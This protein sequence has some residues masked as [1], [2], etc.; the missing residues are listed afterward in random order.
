MCS[1]SCAVAAP[2]AAGVGGIAAEG[3]QAEGRYHLGE[4]GQEG[5]E[6]CDS[7]RA[8]P[9]RQPQHLR[10][11]HAAAHGPRLQH[12][13]LLQVTTRLLAQISPWQ[14]RQLL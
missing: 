2:Q 1:S 13:Q 8:L 9:L 12:R 6:V 7:Q 11:Q 10:V 3:R 14:N 5:G 4:V